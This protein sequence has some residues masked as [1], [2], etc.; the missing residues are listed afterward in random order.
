MSFSNEEGW[1]VDG[2]KNL[3]HPR[4]HAGINLWDRLGFRGRGSDG[5]IQKQYDAL[6]K[7]IL[8]PALEHQRRAFKETRTGK[9][10]IYR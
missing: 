10:R 2:E 8:K 7:K 3:F 4:K 6:R 1:I 9:S 5:M